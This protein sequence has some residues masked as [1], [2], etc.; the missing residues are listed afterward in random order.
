MCSIYGIYSKEFLSEFKLN[1]IHN[2]G[3]VL[4]HRG[5]DREGGEK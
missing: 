3:N 1:K 2:V 5:P 4:K